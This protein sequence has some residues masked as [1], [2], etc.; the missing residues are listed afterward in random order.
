MNA[1]ER[2]FWDLTGHLI[3]R[4]VLS[5]EE[6]GLAN[7]AIDEHSDR[8]SLNQNV[9]DDAP[10]L[11]GTERPTLTGLL[12]LEEPYCDPF[13]KMLIH[14]A[15]VV[16]LNEMHGPGF[17][18]DHGPLLIGGVKGT[19]GLSLHGAGDPHRAHVAYHHQNGRFNVGGVTVTWQLHDCPAGSGGFVCVPGSHKSRFPM[20]RGVRLCDD[21]M[22][23]VIQPEMKAGDVLFFMDGAQTHGTLPWRSENPRRSILYKY[24]ARD[25][26]RGGL[27]SQVAA[28]EI[29]WDEEIVDGMTDEQLAVMYG[30]YSNHNGNVPALTV[31]EGGIVRVE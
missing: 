22:G 28:P 21:D 30:P 6:L 29:Y 15:V 8:I 24:A 5:A 11:N 7:E 2:Y 31:D 26:V 13:R 4:E 10:A 16:R 27:A 20:P 19:E 3:V 18:L 9:T 12:Q 25:S 17:R 14:P 1:E 23:V